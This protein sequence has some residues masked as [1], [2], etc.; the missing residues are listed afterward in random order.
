MLRNKSTIFKSRLLCFIESIPW[1]ESHSLLEDC[2]VL[3][4][5]RF[6]TVFYR[7]LVFLK[8]KKKTNIKAI[9]CNVPRQ[10]LISISDT[11]KLVWTLFIA[12]LYLL[13]LKQVCSA[14]TFLLMYLLQG[15]L[16]MAAETWNKFIETLY[17]VIP[18]VQVIS[19]S[20]KVVYLQISLIALLKKQYWHYTIGENM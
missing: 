11:S 2:S 1:P 17:P 20:W 3:T 9:W 10:S 5:S 19:S 8:K 15:R 16:M 18:I 12:L 14:A 6:L 7:F 4:G 13:S